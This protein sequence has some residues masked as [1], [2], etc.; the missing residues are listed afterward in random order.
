MNI[1][2]IKQTSLGDVLHA[3]AALKPIRTKF[4]DA[5]ITFMA[6][7]ST[8]PLIVNNREINEIIE[9]D[10]NGLAGLLP[11][12]PFRCLKKIA[13]LVRQIRMREYDLA[14]DLQGLIRTVFFLYTARAKKKFVKGRWPGVKGYKSEAI[15]AVDEIKRVIGL[16]GISCGDSKP[17]FSFEPDAGGSGISEILRNAGSSIN[18][19][20]FQF[21][22][23]IS[24]FTRWQ[25]KDWGLHNY[26][27]LLSLFPENFL[28]LFTGAA[29]K[30][31]DIETVTALHPE[32]TVNLAGLI[33]INSF[34]LLLSKSNVL[35]SS[36]GF[37][38][39]LAAA[40][41][42]PV[43]ALFGP[44]HEEK[45]GPFGGTSRILR[46]TIHCTRCYK[47]RCRKGCMNYITPEEVLHAVK[48]LTD[49]S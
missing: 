25:S 11:F 16:S 6:D 24:P 1:L 4:P 20:N 31:K 19:G 5:H 26:T 32:R 23:V 43:V 45:V 14:F 12:S 15:H 2:I 48:S 33:S 30:N 47:P 18:P 9:Y 40:L 8:L 10:L 38:V 13:V 39:H 49:Y 27:R 42:T 36:D 7:K 44:T 22:V 21:I 17:C 29:D 37:P 35:I 41:N 3:T 28:I 34:A 46:D